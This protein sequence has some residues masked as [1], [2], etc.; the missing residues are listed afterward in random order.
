[1]KKTLV[2]SGFL[3]PNVNEKIYH[4]SPAENNFINGLVNGLKGHTEIE[5]LTYVAFKLGKAQKKIIDDKI[6]NQPMKCVYRRKNL[7]LNYMEYYLS[8]ISK[9]KNVDYVVLY[10]VNIIN[11]FIP[12]ICRLISKKSILIL[13]DYTTSKEVTGIKKVI[14]KKISNTFRKFDGVVF[15]S[16]SMMDSTKIEKSTLING[17]I[18]EKDF[19]DF[20]IPECRNT[21]NVLY[22]GLLS[23]VTGVDLLIKVIEIFDFKKYKNVNFFITGKGPLEDKVR[24]ISINNV[25]V[26][27]CGFLS[28]EEYLSCLKT[29]NILLNPRNMHLDQNQNNFPSKIIEY[30]ASGRIIVSTKFSG[31]KS[32]TEN[33]ILVDTDVEK[34]KAALERA[35]DNYSE[36]YMSFFKKNRETAKNYYWK[37]QSDKLYNFMVNI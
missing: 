6:L 12:V 17:G 32:F 3:P 34:I 35:I 1:M 15:L 25:N 29:S 14:A 21:V 8:F 2:C 5:F 23:E 36:L 18:E 22:S 37:E 13:S 4:N 31:H 7:L 10:G 27:Y 28:R 30:I 11:I 9:L 20:T 19:T 24:N 33:L 26:K 16:P